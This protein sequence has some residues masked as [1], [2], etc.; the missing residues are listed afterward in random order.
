M[1]INL[2]KG[3]FL[4]NRVIGQLAA[5]KK[6]TI[7][8]F[9]L[10]SVMVFMWARLLG[11]KGVNKAEAGLTAEEVSTSKLKPSLGLAISFVELPKAEGRND[12]LTRDFFVADREGL[13]DGRGRVNVVLRDGFEGMGA[14]IAEKLKLE[15]IGFGKNPQ[16]FINDKL[17]TVGDK[18]VVDDGVNRYECEVSKIEESAVSIRYGETEITLR[19]TQMT[20]AID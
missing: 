10:I 11:G 15:A 12:V 13:G 1:K 17:L 3:G 14:R 16:A 19:L 18:L 4:A 5:D 9:C 7:M 2:G 20:E 8:A 6:K